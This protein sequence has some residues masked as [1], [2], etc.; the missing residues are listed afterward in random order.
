MTKLAVLADIHGAW[1]ALESVVEALSQFK[2][3]HII[4]VGDLINLGP[5]SRQVVA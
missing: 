2:V 5:F 1:P 4:V 3:D